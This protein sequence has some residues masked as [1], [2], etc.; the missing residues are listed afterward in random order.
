M[1]QK[2]IP[3]FAPYMKSKRPRPKLEDKSILERAAEI[4]FDDLRSAC[5]ELDADD[6]DEMIE[7]IL[8]AIAYE[9]DGYRI[10][11]ALE[12]DGWDPDERMVEVFSDSNRAKQEALKEALA[13]WVEDTQTEAAFKPGDMVMFRSGN[14]ALSTFEWR[15]GRIKRVDA[16]RAEYVVFSAELGHVEHGPG[17][18]GAIVDFEACRPYEST[19]VE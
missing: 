15:V 11:R 19:P 14:R 6:R 7:H 2:E 1:E 4:L 13:L 5:A 10:C 18:L 16:K 9:S 12:S 17:T 8:E 3:G